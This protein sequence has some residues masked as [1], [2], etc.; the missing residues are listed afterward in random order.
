MAQKWITQV[1]IPRARHHRD[2][3]S[4]PGAATAVRCGARAVPSHQLQGA[5]QQRQGIGCGCDGLQHLHEAL[6]LAT[7][8]GPRNCC[9]TASKSALP[10]PMRR[11]PSG[12]S[13]SVA[14]ITSSSCPRARR[15]WA[16]GCCWANGQAT[17]KR[18][19]R[20]VVMGLAKTM[21]RTAGRCGPPP[22]PPCHRAPA[23]GAAQPAN[24]ATDHDHAGFANHGVPRDAARSAPLGRI[25]EEAERVETII[26]RLN[27]QY[28]KHQSLWITA[29]PSRC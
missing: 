14:V 3:A 20:F 6:P 22:P 24:A 2:G 18:R 11:C 26:R 28:P 25:R 10:T 4:P 21:G 5:A 12:K 8:S 27:E 19:T 23:A 13:T 15:I 7:A 16:R 17:P 9:T 29:M 1:L